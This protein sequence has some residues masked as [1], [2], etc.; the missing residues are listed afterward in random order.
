MEDMEKYLEWQFWRDMSAEVIVWSQSNLLT[1]EA[2]GQIAFL[3]LAWLLTGG[4][5]R[6]IERL[7][8]PLL[9]KGGWLSVLRSIFLPLIRPIA[10]L[11]L[12][13]LGKSV[14]DAIDWNTALLVIASSLLTA[15]IVIRFA[16]NLIRN[17]TLAKSFATTAW[18]LA[19]LNIFG[20]LTPL[21]A[22]LKG[23]NIGLGETSLNAYSVITGILAAIVFLW[24]ASLLGRAA[25]AQLS[26]SRG[27]EPSLQVL[28]AKIARFFLTIIAVVMAL[29]F[30]G[31][32]LTAFAV[33]S[34]ALGVGLGFGLQKVVS[35]FMSGIILLLDRSVKPGDVIELGETYGWINKLAARYTSVVTRDGTEFLIPNEDMITQQV[36]NWS[37]SDRNV[38]RKIPVQVAYSSDVELAMQLMLKAADNTDR[39]LKKPAPNCLLRGFGSDGVDLELRMWI[40]DP[41]NGLS[42][43]A[44]KVNLEIWRLFKEHGIEFPFPQRDLHIH[45]TTLDRVRDTLAERELRPGRASS[46]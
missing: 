2:L 25:E 20:L 17:S 34:G 1:I 33:F 23:F 37:H 22:R 11:I 16:S 6:F 13:R 14:A 8:Q 3:V 5:A 9:E 24:I 29:S 32:D 45:P 28:F 38:R 46:S 44:S 42:N 19:A 30:A 31:I 18:V 12:L 15:W 39:V 36:I 7:C 35:N 21:I 27:L 41:Y 26:R 40:D 4:L 10:A 43:V